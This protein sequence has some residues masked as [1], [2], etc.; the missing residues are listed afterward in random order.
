MRCTLHYEL[1]QLYLYT[2]SYQFALL[3][4]HV[5]N[6]KV[7]AYEEDCILIAAHAIHG[8]KWAVIAKL[9]PGRTDN[10]IKNH[11]NS[12]LRCL[13]MRL[14][15]LESRSVDMVENNC[16]DKTRASSEETQ[17]CSNGN[18]IRSLEGKDV[19]SM[20]NMDDYDEYYSRIEVNEANDQSTL[21]R[22][23]ARVS[24]FNVYKT[25]K[26]P[27]SGFQIS[28]PVPVQGSLGHASKPE[29]SICR[30]LEGAYIEGLVPNQCGHDCCDGQRKRMSKSSLLG[31]E[32]IEYVE[33]PTFSSHQ[34]VAI[35][36]HISNNAWLKCGLDNDSNNMD[37]IPGSRA[38]VQF[39]GKQNKR[40]CKF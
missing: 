14:A 37:G 39:S 1:V 9:L 5:T 15:R 19:S 4:G 12:T 31:P 38:N 20:G 21:F 8:N 35:A 36:N 23:L 3:Y 26:G 11:W 25:S 6:Q 29:V 40:S 32:F 30:L 33:S 7:T 13:F 10:A 16:L 24:V 28:R 18:S 22:P 2:L 27:D 34:F 17:S